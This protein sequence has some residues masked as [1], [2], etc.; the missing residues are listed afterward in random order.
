VIVYDVLIVFFYLLTLPKIAYARFKGKRHPKLLQRL[1][2]FLPQP[3][4]RPVIWIHAVSLGEVK[5]AIPWIAL[6]KQKEPSCW[7]CVTTTTATGYAEA[8]KIALLDS[9]LYAPLDIAWVVRRF[10]ARLRPSLLCLVEGDFWWNMLLEAQ[11]SG[12][13]TCLISGKMSQKSAQRWGL[14]PK[15]SRKMFSSLDVAA[16]QTE[17]HKKRFSTFLPLQK[18]AVTGNLK[19]DMPIQRVAIDPLFSTVQVTS[20]WITLSSTHALEEEMLLNILMNTPFS[21]FLAPR[22]PER[23]E[24]VAEL[25]R[26]KNI[27]FL[28]WKDKALYRQERV[29]LVDKMGELPFCYAHSALAIVGGSFIPSL[30]GHNIWEPCLYGCP[31]LFG[32]YM[33]SQQELQ[34]AVLEES[35]GLQTSLE[36]LEEDIHRVLTARDIFSDNGKR[37]VEKRRFVSEKTWEF[38]SS[39]IKN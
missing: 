5:A 31:P 1:G 20:T 38:I 13:K 35:A 21:F 25:L 3:A 6:L 7:I 18:M 32:P 22:H 34:K 33:F 23:F 24:E 10:I 17:E 39:C 16:L 19:F 36:T 14:F 11:R 4:A 9:S 30:G 37:S 26:R 2:F 28:R 12:A 29:I 15:I 8:Q 27:S